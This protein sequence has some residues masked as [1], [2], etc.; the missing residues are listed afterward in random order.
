MFGAGLHVQ[1][2]PTD[3]RAEGRRLLQEYTPY[4]EGTKVTKLLKH[5]DANVSKCSNKSQ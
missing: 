3:R 4:F 5:S 2:G 1:R